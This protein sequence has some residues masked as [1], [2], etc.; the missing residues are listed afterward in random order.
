ML[1][2]G[3][4]SPFSAVFRTCKTLLKNLGN[5][6]AIIPPKPIIRLCIIKPRFTCESGNLSVT[7]ALNGSMAILPQVSRIHNSPA[8]I[9]NALLDGI[10]TNAIELRTA[11]IMK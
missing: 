2:L 6:L 11:P 1:T 7:K 9:H 8:A 10:I 5:K 4:I 3:G